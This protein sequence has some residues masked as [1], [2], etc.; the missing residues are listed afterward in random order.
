MLRASW[1]GLRALIEDNIYSIEESITAATEDAMLG[2]K[3]DLRD[4]VIAAGLGV[5][6][7]KTWRGKMY[8]GNGASLEPAAFV[9]SKAPTII[10][11]FNTGGTISPRFSRFFAIPTDRVP[12]GRGRG[13]RTP[14][15][16]E[17]VE[18]EFNQDL[19]LRRGRNG[20]I[21]G[22]VNVVA[23]RSARRPGYRRAT[24]GRLAQGRQARLVHMFTFVRRVRQPKLLNL[25]AAADRWAARIPVF[26]TRRMAR[27]NR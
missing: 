7:S 16:P 20:S 22:F 17:E 2:L 14:M 24:K 25:Q 15:T 18:I 19:V 13:R 26:F 8:P 12:R 3:D 5:R 27:V 9:W 1:G 11:A 6:L 4:Q 10:V 21:L 23:A